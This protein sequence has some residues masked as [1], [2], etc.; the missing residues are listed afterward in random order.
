MSRGG[1]DEMEWSLHPQVIAQIWSRFGKASVDL[2]ASK[3]NAKCPLW[4]SGV[5][6]QPMS[7][8]VDAFAHRQWPQGLLYAFPPFHLLLPLLHRIHADHLRV[9]VVAPDAARTR[10]FPLLT[11][12]SLYTPW[13]VPLRQDALTQAEGQICKP[14]LSRG[15][16]LMV[17]LTQS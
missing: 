12:L 16:C 7:L 4:F 17:W 5:I 3:E 2:F 13:P 6:E 8:G 14:P 1:P 11:Q 9:I 15:L 10:W